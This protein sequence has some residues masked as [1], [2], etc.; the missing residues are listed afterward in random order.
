MRSRRENDTAL[1]PAPELLVFMTVAPALS[2]L[3]APALD[4]AS[5]C[6]HALIFSIVMASRKLNGK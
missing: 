6:F 5:V 3:M 2:F 1:A 4:P